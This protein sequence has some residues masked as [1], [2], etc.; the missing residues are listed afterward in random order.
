MTL[1]I[2]MAGI[3]EAINLKVMECDPEFSLPLIP[4][5]LRRTHGFTIAHV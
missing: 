1:V 4:L 2:F 5:E 3:K